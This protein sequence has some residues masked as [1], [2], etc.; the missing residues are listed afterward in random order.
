[1]IKHYVEFLEPG[2][3]FPEEEIREVEDRIPAHLIDIPPHTFVIG[4]YDREIEKKSKRTLKS[5]SFNESRRIIF[6][7]K[8]T[9]KE[10]VA[11]GKAGTTLYRNTDSNSTARPKAAVHC[12]TEL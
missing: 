2:S 3:F 4:Y 1:M 10:L 9:L 12:I 11:M 6:G 7:T 8:H 5:E